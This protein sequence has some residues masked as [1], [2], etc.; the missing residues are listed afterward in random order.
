MLSVSDPP[1]AFRVLREAPAA[2]V[3]VSAP[4]PRV[5]FSRFEKPIEPRLPLFAPETVRVSAVVVE[6]R[7]SMPLPVLRVRP[8]A[9]LLTVTASSPESVLIVP[10]APLLRVIESL[11]EPMLRVPVLAAMVAV[12]TP[13][14]ILNVS[15]LEKE[16]ASSVPAL[17]PVIFRVLLMLP[18][19]AF[20][21]SASVPASIDV[22]EV[23]LVRVT[24]SV[25]APMFR[26]PAAVP[27]TVAKSLSASA[28]IVPAAPLLRV[29]ESLPAPMLRVP[30]LEAMVAVSTPPSMLIVSKLEKLAASSVPPLALVIFSVLL[31]LPV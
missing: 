28:L 9:L 31:M 15:K 3:A 29:I 13:P 25:P 1:P 22:V 8:V 2:I 21:V 18:V 7:E 20:S 12:S 4:A 27:A 5:T 11:P 16:A 23:V 26:L 17:A 19:W 14:S 24:V 10:A 6:V 30:V